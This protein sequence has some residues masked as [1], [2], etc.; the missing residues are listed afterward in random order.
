MFALCDV[1]SMYASCEKVFDPSIRHKPVIVLTNNDGCICAACDIAKQMG[2]GKKFVPYFKVRKELESVGAVIRSSNYELYAD[3]SQRMM[4]VCARFAPK[5]HIYSID[6]CFLNFQGHH[7]EDWLSYGRLLRKT[8]WQETRLPIS[9]GVASTPTL[10]KAA[11]H[12]AKKNRSMRGVAVIRSNRQRETIL[13]Q[14][15]VDDVW[16]I[17]R[18][19]GAR[20]RTMGITHAWSLAQ[21]DVTKMRKYFSVLVANTVSELNGEQRL[22]WDD[23]RAPSKEIFSTRSFNQRIQSQN[24]LKQALVMHIETASAKLRRQ[25]SQASAMLAFASNSP[26]DAVGLIRKS[27]LLPF[28]MPISDASYMANKLESVMPRLFQ[29]GVRYYRCGIGLIDL[30]ANEPS[31]KDLFLEDPNRYELMACMDGINAKYGR[32][33]IALASRG[34]QVHR[35]RRNHLS[36]RYTTHWPDVPQIKC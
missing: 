28:A 17:G 5:L 1:N 19:L 12:V 31:Q 16:G 20:L 33:S 15:A 13:R 9:V 21:Q 32:G 11:N 6:E 24:S 18:K 27:V 2:I 14:M 35:M 8:V 10:A 29:Q 23:V 30:A 4:D 25:G 7:I 22:S 36:P 34:K 26:H 3:M